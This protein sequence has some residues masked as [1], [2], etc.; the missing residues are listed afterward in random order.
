M[1]DENGNTNGN[2][3]VSDN[4]KSFFDFENIENT[5]KGDRKFVETYAQFIK[6][7]AAAREGISA[8]V[9]LIAKRF[10][11]PKR[12][13][14]ATLEFD[15]YMQTLVTYITSD[16]AGELKLK[17]SQAKLEGGNPL[18]SAFRKI[19]RAMAAGGDLD[20]LETVSACLTFAQKAEKAAEHDKMVEGLRADLRADIT[21]EI[22]EEG[23]LVEGTDEFDMELEK[24][25]ESRWLKV[26]PSEGGEPPAGDTAPK[27]PDD[28][29]TKVVDS[30]EAALRQHAELNGEDAAVDMAEAFLEKVNNSVMKIREHLA[31]QSG[32]KQ[33]GESA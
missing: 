31:R 28:G 1:A 24:R 22:L 9:F 19:K 11:N 18:S 5:E 10:N 7:S 13:T 27:R 30:I 8:R 2:G 26:V 6:K 3:E 33:G 29:I 17:P 4:V 20:Q 15:K 14:R 23:E 21:E 16:E 25:F 32:M 12:P